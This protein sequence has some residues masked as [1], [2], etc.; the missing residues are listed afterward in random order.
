MQDDAGWCGQNMTRKTT[1]NKY[2]SDCHRGKGIYF[3]G[4]WWWWSR[5][6]RSRTQG[7]AF[8]RSLRHGTDC[9]GRKTHTSHTSIKGSHGSAFT[10]AEVT[11]TPAEMRYYLHFMYLVSIYRTS[12]KSVNLGLDCKASTKAQQIW[13]ASEPRECKNPSSDKTKR[14]WNRTPLDSW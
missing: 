12:S 3:R 14:S 4:W 2:N 8:G 13:D 9:T 7:A 11:F 10:P 5:N 6:R 1:E